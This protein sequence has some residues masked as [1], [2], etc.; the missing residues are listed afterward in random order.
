MKGK[1]QIIATIVIA[2]SIAI[3]PTSSK[4]DEPSAFESGFNVQDFYLPF[5]QDEIN[6]KN[7]QKWPYYKYVSTNWGDFAAHGITTINASKNPHN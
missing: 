3:A 5:S 2:L 7:Q 4:A 1:H 6:S